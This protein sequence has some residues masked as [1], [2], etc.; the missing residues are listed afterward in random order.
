MQ[1]G[2]TGGSG[3]NRPGAGMAAWAGQAWRGAAWLG[4][5]LA[6]APQPAPAAETVPLPQIDYAAKGTFAGGGKMALRHHGGMLR[7]DMTMPGMGMPMTGYFDLAAKKAL[8]VVGTAAGRMAM[9][10][11]LA[12]QVGLGVTVGQGEREGQ[13]TVAGEPCELW[14]IDTGRAGEPVHACITADGIALRTDAMVGGRKETVFEISSLSRAAQD[15]AAFRMPADVPVMK[16]PLP[17]P[18][19]QLPGTAPPR[20]APSR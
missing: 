5:L 18:G 10:V 16:L 19:A 12:E 13:D 2:V 4:V 20:V 11:N 8:M 3:R 15:P 7:I 6:V 17:L 1:R 14:R 9:E